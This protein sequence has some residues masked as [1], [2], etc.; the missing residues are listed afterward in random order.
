M[1][2]SILRI[3]ITLILA[4]SLTGCHVFRSIFWVGAGRNDYK[5]FPAS[6]VK[7]ADSVFN[8]IKTDIPF[9]IAN[10]EQASLLDANTFD[11]F[12]KKTK[13]IA[14]I[15]IRNDSLIYEAYPDGDSSNSIFPS[16][17]VAK[18][19]VSALIGIAIDE[20][21]IKSESD[22]ITK[23]LTELRGQGCRTCNHS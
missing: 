19:F 3:L 13:T 9:E 12:L 22:S 4:S 10:P 17:S 14:F 20:G 21:Y 15:V 6:V 16:F 2:N 1:K 5:S 8:F 18:S 7:N 11:S 23:Y